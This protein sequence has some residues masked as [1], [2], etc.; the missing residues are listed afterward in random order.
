MEPQ[1]EFLRARPLHLDGAARGARECRRLGLDCADRLA[2]EGPTNP[3]GLDRDRPGRQP[4]G[5]G[6]KIPDVEG[7]LRS[8][9][10]LQR[11]LPP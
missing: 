5:I 7:V 8:S 6:Q 11:A 1:R 3:A 10:D 4:E 2:P 9:P